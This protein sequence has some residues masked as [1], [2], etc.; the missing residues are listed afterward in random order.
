MS[1]RR[2]QMTG[3][4]DPSPPP[5]ARDSPRRSMMR[6]NSLGGKVRPRPPLAPSQSPPL[7]Y[8]KPVVADEQT[9]LLSD[10]SPGARGRPSPSMGHRFSPAASRKIVQAPTEQPEQ[11]AEEDD[12]MSDNTLLAIVF[13]VFVVVALG[14]RLFQKLQTI[15]MYNYPVFLN[16]FQTFAY[17]PA[18]FA[19]IIPMLMF[20]KS[21]TKEQTQV[22]KYKF[23]VMGLL[24]CTASIMQV[25]AVNFITNASILVLLQQ[26]AIPIAMAI[27]KLSL[28]TQYT[29]T[30]V[31]G[32]TV[33]C[34]GIVVVLLPQF[35]GAETSE[36]NGHS[37]VLWA[38]VNIISCIPMT[39]SAVYK[40]K[41]LQGQAMDVVYLNGW[42]ALFQFILTIP[43]SIPSAFAIDLPISELIPNVVNGFQCFLGESQ[44]LESSAQTSYE[45]DKCGMAPFYVG[46][47]LVFNITYNILVV[48][49]LKYGS[50]N[51]MYLGSTALVPLTN[52]AFALP[53]MP[54]HKPVHRT[55][56]LGLLVIMTGIFLYRFVGSDKPAGPPPAKRRQALYVGLNSMAESLE[57]LI[58]TRIWRDM[59]SEALLRKSP[60]QIRSNYMMKLGLPP[61]PQITGAG[62]GEFRSRTPPL[63]RFSPQ[64]QAHQPKNRPLPP[65]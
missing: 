47:Y 5:H 16:L 7:Q 36:D 23:A 48:V 6:T 1:G 38:L 19:Y 50:A 24:D 40:E 4:N 62:F 29:Y 53:W 27:S 9:R 58:E 17:I 20:G 32:A 46:G 64:L 21:I 59:A 30:Q 39:L 61:S 22:P 55:D 54:G 33:V 14:N 26:S 25:F 57:P 41:A 3:M 56:I 18:T 45:P 10:R 13:V 52:A 37:Q 43:L 35:T 51:I 42:V 15:P 34:M 12:T 60:A 65:V 28:K 63:S 2:I 11:G 44:V 8:S 31:F 49:I